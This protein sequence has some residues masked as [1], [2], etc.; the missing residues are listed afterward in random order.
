MN[1]INI[2]ITYHRFGL[3]EVGVE[4]EAVNRFIANAQRESDDLGVAANSLFA[5]I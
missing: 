3:G 5:K 1:A 2:Y 4:R